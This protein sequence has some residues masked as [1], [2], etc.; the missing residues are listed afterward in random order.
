MRE[1]V[2]KVIKDL[3]MRENVRESIKLLHSSD[4][5]IVIVT[6]GAGAGLTQQLLSVPGASNTLIESCVPYSTEAMISYLGSKP[7]KFV[8]VDTAL[9]MASVAGDKGVSFEPNHKDISGLAITG[10]I[11]TNRPK[12][13]KNHAVIVLDNKKENIV[14]VNTIEFTQTPEGYGVLGRKGEEALINLVG[15]N[16]LLL[17]AGLEQIPLPDEDYQLTYTKID[18]SEKVTGL[19]FT[20]GKMIE[21]YTNFNWKDYILFP[22]SFNPLHE[23]HK[24]IAEKI[25]A[26]TGKSIVYAINIDHPT[27][28]RIHKDDLNKRKTQFEWHDILLITG[29]LSLFID[30]ARNLPGSSFI[31][32]VDT[33][34]AIIGPC[35]YDCTIEELFKQFD[36]LGTHFYVPD[37]QHTAGVDKAEHFIEETEVL[38]KFKHLFTPVEFSNPISST[39]IRGKQ[40]ESKKE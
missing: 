31:I 19:I 6:T 3:L 13:G 27:K 40:Y 21:D 37:R 23:G 12:K 1:D 2:S 18:H 15:L 11:T 4:L 29:E 24:Q 25:S 5:R 33:L 30:K 28:G 39:E 17:A 7:N 9:R 8:S 36:D 38:R 14:H 10:T 26:L 32:G 35:Q 20:D 34:R 22:G 16:M